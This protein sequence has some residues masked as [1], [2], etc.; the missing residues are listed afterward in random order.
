MHFRAAPWTVLTFQ[1]RSAAEFWSEALGSGGGWRVGR[2]LEL[3]G[4]QLVDNVSTKKMALMIEG[5]LG[6]GVNGEEMLYRTG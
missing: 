4:Q 1:F 3:V 6:G 2:R 5:I